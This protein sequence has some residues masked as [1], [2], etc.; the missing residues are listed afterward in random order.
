MTQP[1]G[2]SE[3]LSLGSSE[4]RPLESGGAQRLGC[5]GGR[6]DEDATV[7]TQL[8]HRASVAAKRL[9]RKGAMSALIDQ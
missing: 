6:S 3:S 7:P 8:R 2:A 5:G 4:A 9:E 1:V